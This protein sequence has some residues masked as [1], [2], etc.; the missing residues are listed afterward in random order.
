MKRHWTIADFVKTSEYI[1]PSPESGYAVQK[2]YCRKC[3]A[4]MQ[5]FAETKT[6]NG[7]ITWGRLLHYAS[8]DSY[9]RHG[10]F[11]TNEGVREYLKPGSI[12]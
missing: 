9:K 6:P 1:D 5:R 3:T 10:R 8:H 12:L 4:D 2:G 7:S 11:P